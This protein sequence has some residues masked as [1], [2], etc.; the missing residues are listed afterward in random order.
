MINSGNKEHIQGSQWQTPVSID[1]IPKIAKKLGVLMIFYDF[2]NIQLFLPI[3]HC[4][5]AFL[6][7]HEY[8]I[9]SDGSR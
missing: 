5:L 6:N 9:Y 4:N 8:I 3:Y 1:F 7:K 2:P